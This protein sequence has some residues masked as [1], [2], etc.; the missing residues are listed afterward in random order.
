[1]REGFFITRE[2]AQD[3]VKA[4]REISIRQANENCYEPT[5]VERCITLRIEIEHF[6]RQIL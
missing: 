6:L 2:E 1:M 4:L 5:F 3:V